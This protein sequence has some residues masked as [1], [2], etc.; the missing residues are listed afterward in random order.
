MSRIN[1]V[2]GWS[3]ARKE[4]RKRALAPDHVSQICAGCGGWFKKSETD[5]D[6]IVPVIDP[7][8]SFEGYDKLILRKLAVTADELQV[9]CKAKCHKAKSES[10]NKIRRE[11]DKENNG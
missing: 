11:K 2:W 9:L 1:E 8:K 6:H 10:E 7:E 3:P 4:A 5:V